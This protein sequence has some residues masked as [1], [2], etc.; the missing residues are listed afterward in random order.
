MDEREI[1]CPDDQPMIGWRL[2]RVRFNDDGFLLA[3]PLIHDPDYERF[4]ARIIDAVCYD[5][6]HPAPAPGCR[7]GLYAALEGTLDSLGGYLRD[8]AH[9]D[10]PPVFAEVACTGRVFIDARGLRAQRIE[11]LRVAVAEPLWPDA[12][13]RQEAMRQLA[14]RYGVDVTGVEAVPAWVHANDAAK[15]APS[16]AAVSA[17][18][19]DRLLHS[20]G[21]QP[22]ASH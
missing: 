12:G 7:C 14:E 20:I 4:P 1:H 3:A 5:G 2:F 21:R 19:L 18:D 9:D 13:A 16:D 22:L 11:V 15:G 17:L 10:D 6:D 8:S